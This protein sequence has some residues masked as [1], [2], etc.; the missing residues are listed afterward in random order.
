MVKKIKTQLKPS[1][2]TKYK[3]HT[4]N[5]NTIVFPSQVL[6]Y[7]ANGYGENVK[8]KTTQPRGKMSA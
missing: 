4:E 2:T 3:L 7:N 6:D 1:Q 5:K 8:E